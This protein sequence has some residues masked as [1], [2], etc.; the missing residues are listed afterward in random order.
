MC[1]KSSEP[2]P[3][4]VAPKS[5]DPEDDIGGW[6]G[7]TAS[8]QQ[9]KDDDF[10]ASESDNE[11]VGA[12]YAP[13]RMRADN[14]MDSSEWG[15]RYAAEPV[16]RRKLEAG[17]EEDQDSDD[18]ENEDDEEE[19][20]GESFDDEDLDASE[21]G[22]E[23]EDIEGS[24]DSADE[25]AQQASVFERVS[26]AAAK[27]AARTVD[28]QLAALAAEDAGDSASAVHGGSSA[29]TASESQ[30]ARAERA[31]ALLGAYDALLEVA[32]S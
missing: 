30:R 15:E 31:R 4:Q 12:N 16:D 9:V 23:S 11:D 7:T 25:S 3:H 21:S 5:L 27:A 6:D 13:S 28:E 18:I 29:A 8:G 24:G 22:E 1:T 17:S 19:D 2:L 32:L 26:G 10:G 14:A 20:A